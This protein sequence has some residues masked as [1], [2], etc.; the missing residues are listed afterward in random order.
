MD[1]VQNIRSN[2]LLI[3]ENGSNQKQ[4]QHILFETAIRY[5]TGNKHVIFVTEKPI[6][7]VP[8]EV[9]S[10]YNTIY[11]KIIF[12][13]SKSAEAVL[14]KLNDIKAWNFTPALVV[15][16]SIQN[17][18][19]KP[20]GGGRVGE[21]L[22]FTYC[23]FLA[24]VLDAVCYYSRKLGERSQCIITVSRDVI[25]MGHLMVEQFFQESNVVCSRDINSYS[26]ALD[27]LREC[28]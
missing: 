23:T 9:F 27:L 24:S 13:Y 19:R 16:E 2:N 17:L 26:D 18:L 25:D 12:V 14:L 1:D 6:D 11:K 28:R 22:N 10:N 5:A 15:L 20:C 7:S 21:D 3:T 8:P 4:L